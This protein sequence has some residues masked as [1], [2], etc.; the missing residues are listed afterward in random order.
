MSRDYQDAK[1]FFVDFDDTFFIHEHRD[2]TYYQRVIK[3]PDTVYD[4]YASPNLALIKF[5]QDHPDVPIYC[6]TWASL[7]LAALPKQACFEKYL[8]GRQILTITT[9]TPADKIKAMELI[10]DMKGVSYDNVLLIDDLYTTNEMARE[11]GFMAITPQRV[12]NDEYKK[13]LS[14]KGSS[15]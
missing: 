11:A 9:A 1:L 13:L 8:P 7:S 2:P 5:L 14:L 12:Q 15:D 6:L 3:N 4:G 10:T